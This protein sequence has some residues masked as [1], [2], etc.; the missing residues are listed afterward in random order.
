MKKDLYLAVV[1][2]GFSDSLG[3]ADRI[4]KPYQLCFC[5]ILYGRSVDLKRLQYFMKCCK[6]C[7]L[8]IDSHN[9]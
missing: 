7:N 1:S 2:L 6:K 5:N 3:R 4:S 9:L 8:I